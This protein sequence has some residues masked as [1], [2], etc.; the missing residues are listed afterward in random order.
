MQLIGGFNLFVLGILIVR[1]CIRNYREKF[2]EA[3]SD[4]LW[5]YLHGRT[6]GIV[7]GI[8]LTLLGAGMI[9]LSLSRGSPLHFSPHF[10]FVIIRPIAP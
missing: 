6:F 1:G 5:D 9:Y 4:D 2:P 3:L 10:P 7:A 8:F